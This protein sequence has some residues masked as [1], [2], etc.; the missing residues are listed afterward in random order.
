MV[1]LVTAI[2]LLEI[3]TEITRRLLRDAGPLERATTA[4]VIAAAFW[5]GSTWAL[6]LTRQLT[7]TA[8]VARAVIVT[9]LALIL[10]AR[11]VRGLNVDV[12]IDRSIL[13]IV[14]IATLPFLLWIHFVLW[15]AAITPPLSPD[16]LS[17]H[18]PR[19]VLFAR[20]DGFRYLTELEARERNIPANYEMLLAE[21]V[22]AQHSDTYTEWPSAVFYVLF[23]IACGALVERWWRASLLP[24]LVTMMFV[25]GIPVLLLHSGAHKNDLMVASFT[26]AAMVFAGRWWRDVHPGALLLLITSIAMAVGTKPQAAGFAIFIAPF[27]LLRMV[28]R[29]TP[30]AITG[31]VAF[32]V[33]AFLLLGGAVYVVNLVEQHALLGKD[34][35]KNDVITYGD[36][37]NLWQGPYVLLAAPFARDARSLP[38]PWENHPWFWRR[39]ELYFSHLG[40]PF[41]LCAI[42]APFVAFRFRLGAGLS[43]EAGAMR[44]NA[45][46]RWVITFAAIAA[47]ILMLPVLF[48]PHG[49]Y[50]ISLPRYVLFIVPVVFGWTVTPLI[51]AMNVR[52]GQAALVVAALSL[53]AYGANL[54]VND[55]FA[56]L[57]YVLW[58]RAHTGTRVIPFDE[59]RAAS[60][61]DRMAGPND[62]IA[63]DASYASWIHPA[64]GKGL[65]RPVYFIPPGDG[66]PVIPT[67]AQWV[68]IDR[69][70]SIMWEAS[71]LEDLSQVE[72]LGSRGI[73]TPDDLRVRRAM[74]HDPHFKLE[75]VR[76]R[77]NQLVFRRVQ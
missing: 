21:F 75:Y 37:E 46:E 23:V 64:F 54:A 35:A 77:T 28:K 71:G 48:K 74:V 26:V 6:A 13:V 33:A 40:I 76:L 44:Q 67:D 17:Y 34:S 73:P 4:A 3:G 2:A 24:A 10:L 70:W 55:A 45:S 59:S 60:V 72:Q 30:R 58:A 62:K 1:I 61:A 11:R 39:Y 57:E 63:I 27:V 53:V 52:V 66:I 47:F 8:L 15:R 51:A 36:W 20:S 9:I 12:K 49:F 5:L 16:A 50:A 31:V 38:V 22:V 43:V 41:A 69:S 56:P 14:A 32:S 19:A 65:T 25:A 68:V 29:L 7:M 18:L 42:A